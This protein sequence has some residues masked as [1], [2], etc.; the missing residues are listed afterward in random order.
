MPLHVTNYYLTLAKR[1]DS[2]VCK[3]RNGS[4]YTNPFGGGGAVNSDQYISNLY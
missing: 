2:S 3:V 4:S 1:Y